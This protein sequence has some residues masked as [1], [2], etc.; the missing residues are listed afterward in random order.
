MT[1]EEARNKAWKANQKRRE[2]KTKHGGGEVGGAYFT[3]QKIES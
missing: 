1:N 3:V 2:N